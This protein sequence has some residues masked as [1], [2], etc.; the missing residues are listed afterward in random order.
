MVDVPRL[1]LV[2]LCRALHVFLPGGGLLRLGFRRRR[3]PLVLLLLEEAELV[4]EVVPLLLQGS[5]QPLQQLQLPLQGLEVAVAQSFLGHN[6]MD[7]ERQRF[8]FSSVKGP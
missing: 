8:I 2:V 7:L 5:A 6:T 1:W 4:V 3:G